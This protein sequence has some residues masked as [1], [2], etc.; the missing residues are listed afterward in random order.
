VGIQ[1]GHIGVAQHPGGG[2][3]VC[4]I[5]EFQNSHTGVGVSETGPHMGKYYLL[6]RKAIT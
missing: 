3:A 1:V 5:G 4:V 2:D 6:D